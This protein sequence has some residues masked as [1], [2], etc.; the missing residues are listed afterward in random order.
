MI[1]APFTPEQVVALNRFQ[2]DGRFHPFTCGSGRRTDSA[3][4]DGNGILVASEQGWHCPYCEYVQDWAH[5]E[6][7]VLS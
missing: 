5:D 3:H 4:L 1:K 6:M 2:R 7:V